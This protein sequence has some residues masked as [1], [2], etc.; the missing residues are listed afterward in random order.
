MATSKT[1]INLIKNRRAMQMKKHGWKVAYGIYS[2]RNR[3]QKAF[4]VQ[5]T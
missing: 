2:L 3:L 5:A 4:T 1:R